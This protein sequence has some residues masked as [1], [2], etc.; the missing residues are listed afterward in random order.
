[1][2]GGTNDQ[3]GNF[4]EHKRELG[5]ALAGHMKDG[6]WDGEKIRVAHGPY[7]ITLDC[8]AEIG[9][10]SSQVVTRF[11]AAYTNSDG[12]SFR[13]RRR[14]WATELVKLIG[15]QDIEVGDE[16]FD[17]EF[18]LQANEPNEFLR[19]MESE[20]IRRELLESDAL[21]VEVR[22]DDGWFG[23]EF[24]EGV[25]ELYLEL[26]GRVTD[27]EVIEKHYDL[28]ADIL[29]QLEK[30]GSAKGKPRDPGL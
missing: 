13:I 12:F 27:A 19:F 15:T 11:R 4:Q 10:L 21:L 30:I 23:P 14:T 20:E 9:G 3:Q 24:P 22:P 7:S 29:D 25:D 26:P 18:V 5:L 1:M 17:H 2:H 28:F 16:P 6:A 8:H